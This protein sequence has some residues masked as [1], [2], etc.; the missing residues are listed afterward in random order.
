M[1]TGNLN[2]SDLCSLHIW[3]LLVARYYENRIAGRAE[4]TDHEERPQIVRLAHQI[5]RFVAFLFNDNREFKIYDA[6]AL[7]KPQ[8]LHI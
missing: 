2:V 6:T 1:Q 8:I 3:P 4:R 5:C 7:T